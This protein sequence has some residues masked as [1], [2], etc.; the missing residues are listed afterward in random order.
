MAEKLRGKLFLS[1]MMGWCDASFC[2][3]RAQGCAMV[4]LGAWVLL[5]EHEPRDFYHPDPRPDRLAAFMREQFDACRAESARRVGEDNV[6]LVSANV[7]PVDDEVVWMVWG[8]HTILLDRT[9]RWWHKCSVWHG[10]H[11]SSCPASRTTSPNAATAAWKR[12]SATRTTG[13]ISR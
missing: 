1:S 12:C 3:A 8:H 9:A 11:E 6:P 13:S 2:A 7:F 10:S 5:E 4:Q